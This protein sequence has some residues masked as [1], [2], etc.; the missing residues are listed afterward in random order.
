MVVSRSLPRR[1]RNGRPGTRN[2]KSGFTLVELLVVITIIGI[3]IALLLPAVQAAREAARRMQCGN[4]L[5]QI[6]LAF[7]NHHQAHGHFP[8]GGWT[9]QWVGDADRGTGS[10]QPG[11][12]CYNILPFIEQDAIYQMGVGLAE[13]PKH[14]AHMERNTKP[15]TL[16]VCPSRRRAIAYPC[17]YTPYNA[18]HASKVVRSDYAGNSGDTR[19]PLDSDTYAGPT[20]LAEGDTQAWVDRF[21]DVASKANGIIFATSQVQIADVRDGTS[22]TY[23]VGEKSVNPDNYTT[24]KDGSDDQMVYMGHNIDICRWTYSLPRQDR[25]GHQ[26]A[27]QFGSAH[28]SA[29]NVVLCDGSVRSVSY[30]IDLAV[31]RRLGNRKD[32]EPVP[33]ADS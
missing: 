28:S 1:S 9:Y 10:R 29:W 14:A 11:G 2:P 31:H 33:A 7:H 23:A 20:T 21:A 17:T 27:T 8:A 16:V 24:G 6:G 4:N 12:W 5:K 19:D 26:F 32:G 30:S 15:L 13:T 18:D 22:N 3:L 25:P